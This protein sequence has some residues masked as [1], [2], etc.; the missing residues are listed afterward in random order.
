MNSFLKLDTLKIWNV[1]ISDCCWDGGYK[2]AL[3]G[4]CKLYWTLEQIKRFRRESRKHN[5]MVNF[6]GIDPEYGKRTLSMK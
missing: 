6:D 2:V 3:H 1:E 5:Q 4:G